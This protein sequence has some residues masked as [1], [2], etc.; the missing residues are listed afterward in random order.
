[1]RLPVIADDPESPGTILK[2]YVMNKMS[3]GQTRLYCYPA[4]EVQRQYYK[5]LGKPHA[6]FSPN[7]P[8]GKNVITKRFHDLGAKLGLSGTLN[9]HSLRSLAI[10]RM[11]NGGVNIVEVMA[12]ARHASVSATT[13]YI[14]RNPVSSI[15]K[16]NALGVETSAIGMS[17]NF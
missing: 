10:T 16:L 3:P 17:K 15:Q 12:T 7:Q 13:A 11:V 6:L 14:Q 1:M 4:S 2:D 5:F 8:I 9:G